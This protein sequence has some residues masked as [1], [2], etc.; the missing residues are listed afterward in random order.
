MTKM[1]SASEFKAKCLRLID[2]MQ[3]DGEP[4]TITKRGKV[5][6]EMVPKRDG[7]TRKSIIGMM[8]GTVTWAPGVDPTAPVLEDD[9]EAQWEAKWDR[10]GFPVIGK[11]R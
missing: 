7:E 10:R 11:D 9:W 4:V 5:V 8:K 6:A 3:K 1:V 2:E